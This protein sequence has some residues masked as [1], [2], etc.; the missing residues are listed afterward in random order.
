VVL[1]NYSRLEIDSLL[2]QTLQTSKAPPELLQLVQ[3]FSGGSYF[4]VREILQFIKEHGAEQFLSAV[5][6]TGRAGSPIPGQCNAAPSPLSRSQSS[7]QLGFPLKRAN[8]IV[9]HHHAESCRVASNVHQAQLDKLLLVRFGGLAPD[10]QRVLRTAS[11]IGAAL[12][13]DT[14]HAVVPPGVQRHLAT[15]LHALV[16]EQWLQQDADDEHMY[17]FLHPHPQQ[18]IYELTPSSERNVL[19]AQIAAYAERTYGT[20]PAYF[21]AL[22]HYYLHCDTDKALQYVVKA[23]TALLQDVATLSEFMEAADLLRTSVSAC[24]SVRDIEVVLKLHSACER[25]ITE[26]PSQTD[27]LEVDASCGRLPRLVRYIMSCCRGSSCRIQPSSGAGAQIREQER[28]QEQERELRA[29]LA[30][31]LAEV[32]EALLK[33]GAAMTPN[34]AASSAKTWQSDFL[35]N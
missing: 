11:I 10:A 17:T 12:T 33:A 25:A 13:Y 1:S 18:V 21:T 34:N 20:D 32:Q 23:V 3:D 16:C 24:R 31:M 4:W 5:R 35:E 15:C 14:L 26:F 27:S 19:Y 22:C 30:T 29:Q 8:S 9:A 28:E 2:C 7:S 6:A